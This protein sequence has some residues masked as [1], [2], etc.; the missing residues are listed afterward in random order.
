MRAIWRVYALRPSTFPSKAP[1]GSL[2]ET[3]GQRTATSQKK[4]TRLT[5]LGVVTEQYVV[6]SSLLLDGNSNPWLPDQSTLFRRRRSKFCKM[7]T[8]CTPRGYNCRG[9]ESQTIQQIIRIRLR[10]PTLQVG[11]FRAP[12]NTLKCQIIAICPRP[13]SPEKNR[14]RATLRCPAS[15]PVVPHFGVQTA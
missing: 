11:Y 13:K 7:A 4:H 9:R 15:A 8:L 12:T 6:L 10:I 2:T 5:E 1:S 3:T 14:G